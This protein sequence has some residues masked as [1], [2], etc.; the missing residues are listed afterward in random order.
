MDDF[1]GSMLSEV[2]HESE[3]AS[4]RIVPPHLPP[5]PLPLVSTDVLPTIEKLPLWSGLGMGM[6][7]DFGS[8]HGNDPGTILGLGTG[9]RLGHGV[10][11]TTEHE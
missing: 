4:K 8:G 9:I 1:W 5:P 11:T 6:G 10:R 2:S 3:R 7:T